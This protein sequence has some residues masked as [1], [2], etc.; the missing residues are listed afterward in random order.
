MMGRELQA[1]V[2]RLFFAEHWKVGTIATQLGIH[3][4][5]VQRAIGPLGPAPKDRPAV[6]SVLDEYKPVVVETLKDYPTLRA[7]RLYDMLV[8]RGYSGSLRTL[9]RYVRKVRPRPAG[10]VFVRIETVAAEQAQVDWGHVGKLAVAGGQRV[11]WVFVIV[12]SW[13]RAM[14]AELVV[15][16]TVHSLLRSL[17]RAA[18]YFDGLPRQWLFDNAKTIVLERDGDVARFHPELLSLC[19]SLH[20]SPRL[21]GV[22]KPHHK[23]SVERAIRY[24]KERFFAARSIH[25]LEQG[26]AQLLS[27]I[28]EVSLARP[29]PMRREMTVAQALEQEKPH[30]LPLPETMPCVDLVRPVRSDKTATVR[31]DT[32]R[33]SV[34]ADHADKPLTLVG[35]DTQVR[36][37]DG[38][39]VVAIHERCWGRNQPVEKPEHRAQIL[40]KKRAAR[41]GKGR[42]RLRTQLPRIDELL[43]RWAD[44]GRNIGSLVART[45]KLLDL[46]GPAIVEAAIAELLDRGGSDYGALCI[47]CEKRRG[48]RPVVL[49][50]PVAE[51]VNE[52]D[53]VPHDLGGYDDE[54]L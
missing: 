9:R 34:P 38:S 44:D 29:H 6:G 2:R 48:K 42:D 13:S 7:T 21:C 25:S 35:S 20:V 32:N 5:A 12:L 37:L 36:L 14:W 50:L 46:Y 47:L 33:Y 30:L 8:A 31:F 18:Q 41:D 22:R 23:G 53:V 4:D 28:D 39:T 52:R 15:D 49:P 3:H 1:E 43:G 19:A 27:F 26:N 17:T 16:L 24:L 40:D 51:Y 45:L 10:E 54:P 11:L